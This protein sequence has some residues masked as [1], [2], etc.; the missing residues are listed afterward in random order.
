MQ[1][2]TTKQTNAT[3]ETSSTTAYRFFFL[4]SV[5]AGMYGVAKEVETTGK[6]GL[7]LRIAG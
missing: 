6:G 7:S 3:G 2:E 5:K 1:E 4:P